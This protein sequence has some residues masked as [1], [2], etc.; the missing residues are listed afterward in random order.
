[1]RPLTWHPMERLSEYSHKEAQRKHPAGYGKTELV[2]ASKEVFGGFAVAPGKAIRTS[3]DI[4][5]QRNAMAM[6]DGHYPLG[7]RDCEV[8]GLSGGCGPEC[9]V[10]IRGECDAN[11]DESED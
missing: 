10:L 2:A 1:M 4:N 7:M 5:H 6:I 8:I 11:W 3:E 9:L